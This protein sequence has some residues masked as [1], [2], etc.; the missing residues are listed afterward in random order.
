MNLVQGGRRFIARIP[1][2]LNKE[3]NQNAFWGI[4]SAVIDEKKLYQASGM[5]DINL[6]IELG[7]R[8]QDALGKHGDIFYGSKNIFQSCSG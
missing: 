3:F 7:I 8:G 5:M 2:F 6:D 4:V 1:A